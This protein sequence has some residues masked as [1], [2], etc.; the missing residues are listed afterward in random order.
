[1]FWKFSFLT[2]AGDAGNPNLTA[3][4]RSSITVELIKRKLE[5]K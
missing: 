2:H 4:S 5:K 1:M 3:N